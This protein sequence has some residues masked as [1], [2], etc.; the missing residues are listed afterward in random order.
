MFEAAADT[1]QRALRAV[2]RYSVEVDS[3]EAAVFRRRVETAAQT[4]RGADSREAMD[5]V[6]TAFETALRDYQERSAARLTR[7]QTDLEASAKAMESFAASVASSGENQCDGI[8]GELER[9]ER[10]TVGSADDMRR[11]IRHAAAEIGESLVQMQRSNQMIV[12]QLMDEIRLL[13]REAGGKKGAASEPQPNE[14]QAADHAIEERLKANQAFCVLYVDL[15]NF[16]RLAARH[17]A[18]VVEGAVKTV[19]R[20]MHNVLG[21]Q[22]EIARWSHRSL[23]AILN[24]QPGGCMTITREVTRA[25]NGSCSVQDNGVSCELNLEVTAGVI[26]HA[27]GGDA[28]AFSKKLTQLASALEKS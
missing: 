23:V 21:P 17:P 19:V 7:L 1:Y 12:A 28:A 4:W 11:A 8:Q 10:S 16:E 20:R 26:D 14:R 27:S 18:A 2:A 13:H 22:A 6:E 24:A 3:N 25:L 15:R 5:P 9:L